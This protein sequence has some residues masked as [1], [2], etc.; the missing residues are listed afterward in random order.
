MMMPSKPNP[1]TSNS[2]VKPVNNNPFGD[3]YPSSAK[4]NFSY[5][6][7]QPSSGGKGF[8]TNPL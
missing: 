7:Q 8:N 3:P 5:G 4:N 6:S 1:T 2:Y